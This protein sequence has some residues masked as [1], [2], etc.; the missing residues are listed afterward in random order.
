MQ[1]FS[2]YRVIT[3]G[4][5]LMFIFVIAAIYTN[6]KD[7]AMK[8]MNAQKSEITQNQPQAEQGTQIEPRLILRRK[9]MKTR[10]LKQEMK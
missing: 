8:K 7:V 4:I 3:A 9:K 2:K 5:V 10:N 1:E 6:T